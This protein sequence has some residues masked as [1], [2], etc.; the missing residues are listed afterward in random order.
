MGSLSAKEFSVK[1]LQGLSLWLRADAGVTTSTIT[2]S[3]ISQIVISGAGV[4]TSNGTYVR[5]SGGNTTFYLN[6]SEIYFSGGNWLL[7]DDSYGDVTYIN[8][9]N[10][11]PGSWIEQNAT[12]APSAVNT[13]STGTP[14]TAVT[15]WADQSGNGNNATA[16]DGPTL[17]TIS[18]KTFVDFSGGY[19]S[20]SELL[21]TPYATMMC[22]ARFSAQLDV[23][24]MFEQFSDGLNVD[25]MAFYWGFNLDNGFRVYNGVNVNSSSLTNLDETYLF[26]STFNNDT[27]TLYLNGDQDG[28]DYCG[29]QV[30][31]G[32]YY[33]GRWVG[34]ERT[35]TPMRMAEIVVYD[36]VLTTQEREK[37]EA[38]LNV[39]YAIYSPIKNTKISIKKQNLGGGKITL[40]KS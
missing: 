33:L 4:S 21:T 20:G 10:L 39:K 27:G 2:P 23:S 3:F 9:N 7:Y 11:D 8:E 36:R 26:G 32:S 22:V 17:T 40:K 5:S 19:F 13:T 18:G 29:E 35:A 16:T 30:P 28:S 38:Y 31:A 25:N 37:V 15:A 12:G 24:I 1:D 34:G 6:N 14:Y